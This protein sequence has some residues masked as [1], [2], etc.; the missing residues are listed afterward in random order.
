MKHLFLFI[1]TITCFEL[2]L[3]F[4][5]NNLIKKNIKIYKKLFK[6]F[7]FKR[8]SDQ[9][10]QKVILIYSKQIFLISIKFLFFICIVFFIFLIFSYIDTNFYNLI[11]SI[12]GFIEVILLILVYSKFKKYFL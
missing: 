11:L 6:L 4:E 12:K 7:K 5:I 9:Y 2:Y 10:K 3:F 1:L 8:V